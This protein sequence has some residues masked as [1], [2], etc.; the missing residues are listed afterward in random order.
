MVFDRVIRNLDQNGIFVMKKVALILFLATQL[1]ACTE[2]GSEAWCQGMQEKPK[3]DWT[4]NEASDYA[5]HCI[6]K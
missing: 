6:F 5:K 2:V 1:M 3:G 4:A